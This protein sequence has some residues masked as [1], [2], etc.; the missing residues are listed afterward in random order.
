M[1]SDTEPTLLILG[2]YG[3]AGRQIAR[4][5]LQHRD[6]AVTLAG[7]R[8]E[9]ARAAA[10]ALR[11]EFPRRTVQ[12]IRLDAQDR[13]ALAT[14]FSEC[15]AVVVCLPYRGNARMVVTTAIEAGIDY[16]D[17]NPDDTKH[18]TL[19]ARATE[20]RD[21]GRHF[22][23]D[24]GFIPGLPAWLTR[25][26]GTYLDEIEQVTL[27]SWMN[28]ASMPAGGAYD[29]MSHVGAPSRVYERGAW[30]TTSLLAARRIQFGEPVGTE[31]CFPIPLAELEA[32]PDQ[33]DIGALCL[34]Q[35]GLNPVANLIV[36]AWKLFGL[37]GT[38]RGIEYGVRL[39]RW[40]N[41][42]FSTPPFGGAMVMHA[43]GTRD[44]QRIERSVEL[45]HDDLYTATAI[46][47]VTTLFHLL[48][49]TLE[50]PGY[51]FMGHAVESNRFLE[52]LQ[53]LGLHVRVT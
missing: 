37:S 39:F 34:Y 4:M 25:L 42:R 51:Q 12:G 1:E 30:R 24:A 10:H 27:G 9:R 33:L 46:P 52:D 41:T 50:C 29:L 31:W 11:Q 23:V 26:A 36:A 7:R 28:D 17:I 45:Y 13:R 44:G 47:V 15:D 43:A 5:L 49:G 32:L 16:V 3:K 8:E 14:A 40:T 21:A 2:G 19:Q 38:K 22:I 35:G 6:V 48:D 53:R 18:D 20:I